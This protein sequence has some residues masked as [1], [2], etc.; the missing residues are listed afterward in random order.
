MNLLTFDIEEW[1]HCDFISG[2]QNWD[3]Y[4]V[5][6]LKNTDYILD[7]LS[8]NNRKST[9]FILGWIAKKYPQVVKKIQKEGHE[10]GCH[11]MQHRLVHTLTPKEFR[12]DT[13]EAIQTIAS[14]TGT[15]IEMYRAP[16]FSITKNTPWAFETLIDLGIKIDASIFPA[17]H[18]YGGFPHFGTAEPTKIEVN[19]SYIKEFPMSLQT[20]LNKP[21][22]FSGGGFF[23]LFPYSL[24]KKWTKSSSYVMTYFHPRDFDHGQQVLEHLPLM[25]KFKSY[26]GLK[27]AGIKFEKFVEDFETTSI[28]NASSFIDWD[29]TKVIKID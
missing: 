18:D 1:F 29:K 17:H 27:G 19:G 24:I 26:Y 25:R 6:I 23:R 21:F 28:L 11:S 7:V 14:V 8:N 5:R 22:V 15:E 20:V 3:N 12:N 16:A 9:F 2:D 4:E 10:I 13:Y